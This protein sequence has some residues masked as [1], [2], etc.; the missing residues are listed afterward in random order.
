MFALGFCVGIIISAIAL[1]IWS[2]KLGNEQQK[3]NI[4]LIKEFRE[5]LLVEDD[6]IINTKRYES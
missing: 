4:E 5:G 6:N 1:A 2:N 3:L